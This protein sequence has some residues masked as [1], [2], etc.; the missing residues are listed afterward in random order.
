MNG[1]ACIF[2]CYSMREG[3]CIYIGSEV[4][5]GVD[6]KSHVTDSLCEFVTR[7][8]LSVTQE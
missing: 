7:V 2:I 1:Q 8:A 6:C 5:L 4:Y 3:Y